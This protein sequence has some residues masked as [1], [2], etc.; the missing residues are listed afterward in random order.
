MGK[1]VISI[2]EFASTIYAELTAYGETTIKGN[3]ENV[4][5]VAKDT[6]KELKRISPSDTGEYA[7]NWTYEMK[8]DWSY[9]A[10]ATVYNEKKGN[11]T[12]LLE[13]GHEIVPQGGK[14]D[15]IPHISRAENHAKDEF[16]S[17]TEEL[18]GG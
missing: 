10:S 2:D 14:V 6:A 3:R 11:I 12:H 7:E 1:T 9:G 8:S 5:R 13:N 16:V 18:V 17:L 15:A 4:E